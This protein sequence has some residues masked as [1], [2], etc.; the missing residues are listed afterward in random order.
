MLEK[1]AKYREMFKG[2]SQEEIYEQMI[3]LG[4][5]LD[6]LPNKECTEQNKVPGCVSGV[7]IELTSHKDK[8]HMRSTSQSMIVKGYLYIIE[9]VLE[10]CELPQLFESLDA[11]EVFAKTSGIAN[12]MLASRANTYGNVIA[13]LRDLIK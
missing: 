5:N 6:I 9:D 2:L 11:I 12:S 10:A 8:Y 3:E 7:F 13:F 1:V 4:E